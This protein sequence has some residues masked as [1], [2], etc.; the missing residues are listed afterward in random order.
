MLE[1]CDL[2][3]DSKRRSELIKTILTIITDYIC[4]QRRFEYLPANAWT[5]PICKYAKQTN[6]KVTKWSVSLLRGLRD[7]MSASWFSQ[8]IEMAGTISVPKSTHKIKMV[9]NGNGTPIVMKARKG[10]ISGMLEDYY[11]SKNL[12]FQRKKVDLIIVL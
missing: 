2:R 6:F 3:E 10:E 7:M 4:S 12:T 8:A 5:T 1:S 11:N 9:D